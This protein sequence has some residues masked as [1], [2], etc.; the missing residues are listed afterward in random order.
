MDF[1]NTFRERWQRRVETL[2]TPADLAAWLVAAKLTPAPP[3]VTR[4]LL[5]DA[6]EL[7][8]AIDAGVQAHLDGTA[9]PRRAVETV[10][11]WLPRANP[12]RR[13]VT[14][15]R[16]CLALEITPP[17]DAARHAVGRIALDAAQMLG[18]ADRERVRVCASQTCSARFFDHSPSGQR[19]WCSMQ[20]C[21]NVEKA[22]RHRARSRDDLA[23]L[24]TR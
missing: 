13:L 3:T 6:R 16:G 8:E 14:A 18:T 15:G 11:A 20:G 9:T 1:V 2:V 22:R 5:V 24:V 19:R 7:R 17:Q 23:G 12:E 4:R 10:N 21:G